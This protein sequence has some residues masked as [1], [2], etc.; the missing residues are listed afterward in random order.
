MMPAMAAISVA[1]PKCKLAGSSPHSRHPDMAFVEGVY[2]YP[3]LRPL[4]CPLSTAPAYAGARPFTLAYGADGCGC[5]AP[6]FEPTGAND[7]RVMWGATKK[8]RQVSDLAWFL[9]DF[10]VAGTGSVQ[11]LRDPQ[12]EVVAGT[13]SLRYR[14]SLLVFPV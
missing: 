6:R 7:R 1:L 2:A 10:M 12:V 5:Q 11:N 9:C 4:P 8:T 14:Q 13:R 3:R